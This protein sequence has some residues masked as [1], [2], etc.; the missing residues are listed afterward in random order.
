M[1][2]ITLEIIM[3]PQRKKEIRQEKKPHEIMHKFQDS[4]ILKKSSMKGT[5]MKKRVTGLGLCLEPLLY[6]VA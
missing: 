6:L 2:M 3:F 4:I 1:Y 5:N